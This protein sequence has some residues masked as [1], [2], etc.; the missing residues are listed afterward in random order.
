MTARQSIP[1]GTNQTPDTKQGAQVA[2]NARDLT[3]RYITHTYGRFPL[4]ITS[5]QGSIIRDDAGREYIDLGTGIAVNGLGIC[6]SQWVAAVT[7]QLAK[8]AHTSNLYYTAPP[9][10]LA[11]LLCERTGMSKVFFANSG[12]EANE[13][14]FK[15][16]RKYAADRYGAADDGLPARFT[17]LTLD[18]SFHGRTLSALAATGQRHYHELFQPLTPGFTQV[19]TADGVAAVAAAH[20][21]TPLAGVL[22][23]LIQGE[24]GINVLSPSYVHELA[25]WCADNDVLFM[26]DEVQ[27]GN[28]RT[29]AL[30]AFQRYHVHPDV[31]TTAKG[32]GG[33]LPLSAALL[34]ERV[35]DV[36]GPGDHATT[37][38]ANPAICAG[39]LSI[40]Q[41]TDDNLL[42]GVR[43]REAYIRSELEGAPG[44]TDVSGMGLI[45]GVST[46]KPA[47]DIVAACQAAG[48]L[49]LTA[50]EKVRLL[51]ALNI[52]M[53][54][55]AQAIS[56][57]KAVCAEYQ[58][59]E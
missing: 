18:G 29:G 25:Q 15:V 43:E 36:L 23:E 53:D 14:A 54:L 3:E 11:R 51:P 55:L 10:Q 35:A 56:V 6:D 19:N 27:T 48:V 31:V 12:A 5:G 22:I 30:Y 38:G 8:V 32:I 26:V 41:R 39:A 21:A 42:A 37:F 1:Q 24:G 44:I 45:L 2:N 49:V 28:G 20:Q 52:P 4:T 17:I 46:V 9:A 13:A 16:A 33:G 58:C 40:L 50:K 59:T 7:A 47:A 34:A 57:L